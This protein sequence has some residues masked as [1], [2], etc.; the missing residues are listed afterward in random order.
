MV[1]RNIL[2][3][4]DEQT[5]CKVLGRF[6]ENMGHNNLVMNSGM[7]VVDF[8]MNKKVIAGLSCYDIDVMLLDV[9]MPD[10]DGLTVLKQIS[11]I[12]G[13]IQ[14]IVLT[15]NKDV[16]RAVTA[17]NLGAI[18]YIIKGDK[19]MYAR[20]AASVNNAI[21]KKNL[22]YQVSHLARKSK[23]QVAFSDIIGQS[24]ALNKSIKL[25]KKAINSSIPILIEG[26]SGSGKELLAR[27]I[28]GSSLRSGKP[29]VTVEC[30]LLKSLNSEEEL[31]GSDRPLVEGM[32]KNIGKIREANNG[33]IFFKRIDTLRPDLQIKLL[34]FLQEGEFE[35]VGSKVPV[36]VNIQLICSTNRDLEKMAEA[37][38]FREDLRYRI[39]AF[40]I[41]MPSLRE[42]GAE[43]IQML[44]ENF[45]RN[46]SVNENKKIRGIGQE[47]LYLLCN[48]DWEDNVRQLKNSIFRAVVLCD[49]DMLKSEHFPQ[50]L[51]KENNTLTKSKAVIKENSSINSELVDIFDDDG[52]CKT[53]DMIEEE[54]VR[55]LVDIYNGNLS[56]VAKRLDVGRSTVYRKLRISE[57]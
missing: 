29:F 41:H 9:S 11:P 48:Y 37:K 43:D 19:D 2:I 28:H 26:A 24:E 3:V 55:R 17:I 6:I 34:R 53:L 39:A 30:D 52:N 20:V 10:I 46:F 31:F 42:R 13:D 16:S 12:K 33:T 50:L 14:V 56:E 23:D 8:F 32:T 7:E 54:V 18:D 40:P 45:C 27:A 35:P 21:E 44:A 15:A 57:Q 51:N 49:D 1:R 22:K 36:R 4:D 47:A 38:K 25:A 5:Q